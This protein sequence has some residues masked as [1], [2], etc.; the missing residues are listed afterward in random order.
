MAKKTVKKK[1]TG[2]K[3]AHK[4][5]AYERHCAKELSLW[6]TEDS[7][8][9]AIWRSAS[10]GGRATRQAADGDQ[11]E[12][13]VGDL[14]PVMHEAQPFFHIFAVECKRVHALE[15]RKFLSAKN[16]NIRDYWQQAVD[17][18]KVAKKK[19]FAMMREDNG[20]DLIMVGKSGVCGP[21]L[22]ALSLYMHDGEC[23][24]CMPMETFFDNFRPSDIPRLFS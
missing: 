22:P 8:E 20:A 4:G 19:P 9:D 12:A 11:P 21:F 17:Q 14:I 15:W 23:V 18:A 16:C 1:T 13:H 24:W 10:S 3:S 6:L 5:A 7:T 2:R